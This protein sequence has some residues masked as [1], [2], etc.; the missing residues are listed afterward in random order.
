MNRK[1]LKF[2]TKFGNGNT[3]QTLYI[4]QNGDTNQYKIG[5]TNNLNKRLAQLQTGCPRRI[6][7]D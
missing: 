2:E 3:I 4:L 6:K 5:I 7:S 1:R